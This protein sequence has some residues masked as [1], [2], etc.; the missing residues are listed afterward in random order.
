M[1]C[2]VAPRAGAWIEKGRRLQQ[3]TGGSSPLAQGRGL[4]ANL[5]WLLPI[6]SDVALAQGR[7]LKAILRNIVRILRRPSRRAW[8]KD[9]LTTAQ[10]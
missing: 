10:P 4:K 1:K 5:A 7:G 8:M 6:W 9:E 2:R 3:S